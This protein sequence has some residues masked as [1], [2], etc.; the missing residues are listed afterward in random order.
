[1]ND[2][3]ERQPNRTALSHAG[4]ES[5]ESAESDNQSQSLY[6]SAEVKSPRETF[7]T[8]L[9]RRF[10]REL[11]NESDVSY[12][13]E[14][15]R[16]ADFSENYRENGLEVLLVAEDSTRM[17]IGE[18]QTAR[19]SNGLF[20]YVI[21]PGSRLPP[22]RTVR[23]ALDI[24]KP[25]EAAAAEMNGT[26]TIRQGEWFIVPT[27]T[28][29]VSRVF[30]GGVSERP[31]NGS[32]LENHVPTEYAL[33][34]TE[35]E[36]MKRFDEL[37]PERA[38]YFDSAPAVFEW[39]RKQN[40]LAGKDWCEVPDWLPSDGRI[41]RLAEPIYVRGTLRHRENDHY[42]ERI[43]DE[44]HSAVTHDVDVFTIDTGSMT[45]STAATRVR[46]D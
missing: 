29:P 20:G 2:P 41:R 12:N 43:G 23:E 9:S 26:T 34:I 46:L 35:D 37:C 19:D 32:P 7:P 36:F 4:G 17:F 42:M 13:L 45:D 16:L 5:A 25:A 38:G 10:A 18:D 40:T 44:W 6:E 30:S 39:I 14:H 8:W 3:T 15:F 11:I 27:E 33:G 31:F 28:E 1:M 21:G 22:V 24:L